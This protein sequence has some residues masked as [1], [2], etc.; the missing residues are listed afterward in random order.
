M[1]AVEQPSADDDE[2]DELRECESDEDGNLQRGA[3][4]L[5]LASCLADDFTGT[6]KSESSPVRE[7]RCE[8]VPVLVDSS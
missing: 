2:H 6:A 4:S 3:H 8:S 1:A 5:S 7:Y